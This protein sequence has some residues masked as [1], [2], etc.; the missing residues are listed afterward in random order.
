MYFFI[1]L[2]CMSGHTCLYTYA[3]TRKEAS[4]G[5]VGCMLGHQVLN[6]YYALS[7]DSVIYYLQHSQDYHFCVGR[8]L[9]SPELCISY[10]KII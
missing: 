1:P 3:L 6:N 8:L 4:T 5:R 7:E 2:H 9:I 10:G